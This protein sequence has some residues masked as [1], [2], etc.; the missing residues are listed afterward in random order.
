MPALVGDEARRAT[1]SRRRWKGGKRP[2]TLVGI[3]FSSRK[4]N[5]DIPVIEAL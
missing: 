4:R 5:I 2:V 1:S 3:N